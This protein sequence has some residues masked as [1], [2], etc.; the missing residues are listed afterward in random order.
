MLGQQ[1]TV[2]KSSGILGLARSVVVKL[3]HDGAAEAGDASE[4]AGG[5]GA[6]VYIHRWEET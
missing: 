3:G 5:G 1:Q 6:A 4:F 2:S